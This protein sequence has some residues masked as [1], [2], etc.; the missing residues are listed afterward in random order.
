MGCV[1]VDVVYRESYVQWQD[2]N[3]TEGTLQVRRIL[4]RLPTKMG[5]ESGDLY[6]EA[7]RKT[8]NSRRSIVIA[9]VALE[10][11]KQHRLRQDEMRRK[12]G[13]AWEDHDYVFCT[14]VG[15]HNEKAQSGIR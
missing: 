5:K 4:S 8:K 3:F 7:D 15:K 1:Q 10:A 2:I 13:D 12:A 6:V 14:S 11:L 9:D